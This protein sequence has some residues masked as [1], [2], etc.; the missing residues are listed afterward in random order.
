MRGIL[1]VV[2]FALLGAG[3]P[4]GLQ[5]A[6]EDGVERRSVVIWSDGTPLAADLWLRADA[7]PDARLPGLLLVHGWGGVKSHLNQAY[8]PH[9]A[10]L[11]IVVLTFDYR[12]WGESPGLYFPGDRVPAEGE[13]LRRRDDGWL[14][15]RELVDP[16]MFLE[17]VRNAMAFLLGETQVDPARIGVWGTSLGGGLALQAAI[18]HPR[19]RVLIA[20][21]GNVNPL[22]GIVF[23]PDGSP[24]SRTTALAHRTAR[25]RGELPPF[26]GAEA[27]LP[28]LRGV[29]NW[30]KSY[31]YDPFSRADELQA[32]TLIVDAE[33]EE[34]FDIRIMGEALYHQ[35]RHRVPAR[36]AKLPGKHYDLYRGESY[37]RALAMQ[38]EWLQS[39]LLGES[40]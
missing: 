19:T 14:E 10:R 26:P 28:G 27:G 34:L 33:N 7:A 38:I 15:A 31:H 39:H 11:G 8:A 6:A 17:D 40:P 25:A 2:L 24:L 3:A 37:D 13:P 20:Q 30:G 12:T 18:D 23:I 21:I 16:L 4:G 22:G 32:A 35:I 29:M 1:V 9:F 36:Y 5:A